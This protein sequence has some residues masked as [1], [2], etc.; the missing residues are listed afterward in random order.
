MSERLSFHHHQ[1]ALPCVYVLTKGI[2]RRA[3]EASAAAAFYWLALVVCRTRLDLCMYVCKCAC[4]NAKERSVM[5]L[6]KK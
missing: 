5:P 2:T 4:S 6:D 3:I 1:R